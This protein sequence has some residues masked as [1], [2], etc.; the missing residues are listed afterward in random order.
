M[1]CQLLPPLLLP[2]PAGPRPSR[3]RSLFASAPIVIAPSTQPY[4]STVSRRR[5][6]P[7]P[8]VTPNPA[9]SSPH[10]CGRQRP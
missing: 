2:A 6:S 5:S 3:G 8:S 9:S 10:L 7:M 4:R 1:P